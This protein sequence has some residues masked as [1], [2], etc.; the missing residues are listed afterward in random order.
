MHQRMG[1][2]IAPNGRLLTSGF[3]SYCAT[4]RHSPNAGNG[5]G[6]VIREIKADG[7]LG[8]IYFIRY[9]RHAGFDESNTNYPFYQTS[10]DKGFIE[11][12]NALLADKLIT[13]QWWEEDR[14]EDGFYVINPGDAENAAFFSTKPCH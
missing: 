3:Y 7:S 14:A 11:A 4:P 9:N 5:L 1:F 10:P 8:P 12:C 2:Y 6:R 13:L